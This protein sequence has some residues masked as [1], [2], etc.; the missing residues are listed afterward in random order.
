MAKLYYGNGECTIEGSEIRGVEI[1]YSGNIK[2]EKTAGDNFAIAHQNKG[3]MIFPIGEGYLKELFKYSGTLR[4]KSVIVADNNGERVPCNI[5]RVMDY[6]NLL[7]STAETMTTNAEDLSSGYDGYK[8][9][10]EISIIENMDTRD[11]SLHMGV[12]YYL[13]DGS[14]YEG[15]YHIHLKDSACMTGATHDEKSQDLYFRQFERTTSSGR[16]HPTGNTWVTIKELQ[17]FKIDD[18]GYREPLFL[19]SITID[20]PNPIGSPQLDLL[21]VQR[22]TAIGTWGGAGEQYW[23]GEVVL[24]AALFGWQEYQGWIGAFEWLYP[25]IIYELLSNVITPGITIRWRKNIAYMGDDHPPHWI[26]HHLPLI[27]TPYL[28][29]GWVIVNPF[30]TFTLGDFGW[31]SPVDLAESTPDLI[32]PQEGSRINLVSPDLPTLSAQWV[33]MPEIPDADYMW[34][35]SLQVLEPGFTYKV[36]NKPVRFKREGGQPGPNPWSFDIGGS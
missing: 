34:I 28:L 6:S 10:N 35:G 29:A 21:A 19:P 18:F 13:G 27:P 32:S 2:L 22:G 24:G 33:P 16:E 23:E 26:P 15:E 17:T 1:R 12:R 4:I 25:G 11:K 36:M 5:K 3:I 14:P 31:D 7:D 8:G 20:N 30:E 9:V